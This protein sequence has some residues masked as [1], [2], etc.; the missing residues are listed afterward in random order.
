MSLILTTTITPN[1]MHIAIIDGNQTHLQNLITRNPSLMHRKAKYGDTPLHTAV[2]QNQPEVVE[3]L[4]Q[5]GAKSHIRNDAGQTP[6]HI[7]IQKHFYLIVVNLLFFNSEDT[8]IEQFINIAD[9]QRNRA[10]HLAST[11]NKYKFVQQLIYFGANRF[12]KNRDGKTALHLA[13]ENADTHTIYTLVT[14]QQDAV[15][16]SRYINEPDND[17]NTAL[18]LL[19]QQH[20][21]FEDQLE[22]FFVGNILYLV[23]LGG[24]ILALNN[25][26]QTPLELTGILDHLED[27]SHEIIEEIIEQIKE[28]MRKLKHYDLEQR[29]LSPQLRHLIKHQRN[30]E[31]QRLE[32]EQFLNSNRFALLQIEE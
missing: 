31:N 23:N 11:I 4:I 20:E 25:A 14:T 7:A 18:H 19:A 24:N 26:Q 27:L 15:N 28:K 17:G 32:K 12:K 1:A 13:A 9:N 5:N 3:I 21:I 10:I 30:L 22:N 8:D 29:I 16:L 6:L 2:K